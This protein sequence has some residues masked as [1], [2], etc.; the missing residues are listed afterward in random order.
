M[1]AFPKEFDGASLAVSGARF[2]VSW[3][4]VDQRTWLAHF[5]GGD[6]RI[7]PGHQGD[8]RRTAGGSPVLGGAVGYVDCDLAQAMDLGDFLLAVGAVRDAAALRPDTRNLTVNQITRA[9]GTEKEAGVLPLR[10][11]DF[12]LESLEPAAAGDRKLPVAD[13]FRAVLGLRQWGLM[14]VSVAHHGGAYALLT[15]AAMQT[16]HDPPRMAV[17]LPRDWAGTALLGAGAPAM[18]SLPAKPDHGLLRAMATGSLTKAAKDA[19]RMGQPLPGALAWFSLATDGRSLHQVGPSVLLLG[20]VERA[21]WL[22]P[23][24]NNLRLQDVPPTLALPLTAG[25]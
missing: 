4:S 19:A 3:L 5:A 23:D 15:G 25:A 7:D 6:N 21:D 12:P 11:F 1:V 8:F 9:Q 24:A 17:A 2:A 22:E 16:S 10:A 18:L 20:H 13:R 14:Y